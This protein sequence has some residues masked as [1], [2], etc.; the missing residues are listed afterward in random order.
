[1][2]REIFKDYIPE[3]EKRKF[4]VPLDM[5][6]GQFI[7]ILRSR[8]HPPS[9]K[10][11]SFRIL[12]VKQQPSWILC[13]NNTKMRMDSFTCATAVRRPLDESHYFGN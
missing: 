6:V 11:F 5:S 2:C 4:L 1:C 12:C 9:G 10:A 8:L 7:L 13:T 3:M